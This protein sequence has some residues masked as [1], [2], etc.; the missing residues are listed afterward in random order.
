MVYAIILGSSYTSAELALFVLLSVAVCPY[1]TRSGISKKWTETIS[2]L[3]VSVE[4]QRL[5]R[6]RNC[7]KG[8]HYIFVQ[9]LYMHSNFLIT[10]VISTNIKTEHLFLRLRLRYKKNTANASVTRA[11]LFKAS[12][13]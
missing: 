1:I 11:Q 5:T 9:I 3:Q 10:N 4:T 13:A 8:I 2:K 6:L 12:L 7:S